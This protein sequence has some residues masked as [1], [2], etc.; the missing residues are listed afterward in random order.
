MAWTFWQDCT[1]ITPCNCTGGAY[2]PASNPDSN[3]TTDCIDAPRVVVACDSST[4]PCGVT[5]QVDVSGFLTTT[6]C[7]GTISYTLLSYDTTALEN[8]SISG[9]GV[10]QW[11]TTNAAEINTFARI[12]YLIE[13]SNSI[14]SDQG[15]VDVCI[16]SLCPT[17]PCASGTECN[18]CTGNCDPI[19]PDITI[20]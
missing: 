15:V 9:A 7:T 8:V 20:E 17:A 12:T 10:V 3:C 13:C 5:G 14:L 11:D 2:T 16:Q 4:P 19:V 18:P 1:P 6:A